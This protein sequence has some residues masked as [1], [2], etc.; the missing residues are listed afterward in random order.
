MNAV[1]AFLAKVIHDCLTTPDGQSFAYGKVLSIPF[2]LTTLAVPL[3]MLGTGEKVSLSELS[4]YF[5]ACAGAL[6]L[7]VT[8]THPT[9]PKP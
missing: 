5:P 1:I 6:M 9:E 4:V 8:G 7:L 3:V 2:G